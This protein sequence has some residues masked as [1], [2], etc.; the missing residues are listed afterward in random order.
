MVKVKKIIW[1][2]TVVLVS[3]C[4]CSLLCSSRDESAMPAASPEQGLKTGHSWAYFIFYFLHNLWSAAPPSSYFSENQW[5]NDCSR[6]LVPINTAIGAI[7]VLD[8]FANNVFCIHFYLNPRRQIRNHCIWKG[9]KGRMLQLEGVWIHQLASWLIGASST[10]QF[11]LAM[12]CHGCSVLERQNSTGR[13]NNS[14]AGSSGVQIQKWI[15]QGLLG[16][17]VEL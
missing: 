1:F 3:V 9:M 8:L 5:I 4:S 13:F 10:C 17:L 12:C 14:I 7:L 11:F 15:V 6:Y 16:M 2:L